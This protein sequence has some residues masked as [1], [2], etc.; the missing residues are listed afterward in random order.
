[1]SE[2]LVWLACGAAL[3]AAALSGNI[4]GGL[5]LPPAQRPQLS[6]ILLVLLNFFCLYG[7]VGGLAWLVSS[8]SNRR[9]RAMTIV[10]LILLALFLLN[11]LAAFWQPLEKFAFLSP[12]HYHRPV[13]VL[14]NGAWP[15]KDLGVLTAAGGILWLAGGVVFARRDLCTV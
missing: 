11:Y 3:L 6:R 5:A 8:L 9:G 4:L 13:D 1:L 14:G 10:F 7:A 12:L 2:T 15:W